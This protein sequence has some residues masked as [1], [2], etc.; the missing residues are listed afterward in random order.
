MIYRDNDEL[1]GVR[2]LTAVKYMG[3]MKTSNFDSSWHP[4]GVN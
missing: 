1:Q 4:N 2:E 3:A